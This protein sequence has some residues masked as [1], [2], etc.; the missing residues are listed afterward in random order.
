MR[1]L[2]LDEIELVD[3][4]GVAAAFLTGAG[5]GAFAGGFIAGLPGIAGGALIGGT[6]GV[7]LYLI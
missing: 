7:C 3:G 5:A 1:E 4:E 6:I 2:T